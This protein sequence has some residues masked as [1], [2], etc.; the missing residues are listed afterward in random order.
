MI[1]LFAGEDYFKWYEWYYSHQQIQLSQQ[2]RSWGSLLSSNAAAANQDNA[3]N[4][5]ITNF[6]I[7]LPVYSNINRNNRFN[8]EKMKLNQ[9][10]T[11]LMKKSFRHIRFTLID[12]CY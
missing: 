9:V 3:Y 5:D 10:A 2:R 8:D 11:F 4:P 6:S 7:K 1:Q 12:Y